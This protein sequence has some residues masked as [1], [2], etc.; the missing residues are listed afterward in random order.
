LKNFKIFSVAVV[1][2]GAGQ[3]GSWP[4]P[5]KDFMTSF[6]LASSTTQTNQRTTPAKPTQPARPHEDN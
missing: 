1:L 3:M 2:Y 6:D 5:L 4:L